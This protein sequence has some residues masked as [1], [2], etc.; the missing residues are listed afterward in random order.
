MMLMQPEKRLVLAWS[1]DLTR[2]CRVDEQTIS[3]GGFQVE[4]FCAVLS[5][6]D[7]K[8]CDTFLEKIIRPQFTLLSVS[9]WSS[10][11]AACK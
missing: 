1:D 7:V 9:A 11:R 6:G 3:F 4:N 2:T 8:Q 10:L 5:A